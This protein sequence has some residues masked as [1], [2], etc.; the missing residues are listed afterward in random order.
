MGEISNHMNKRTLYII[1]TL[2][3]LLVYYCLLFYIA[4]TWYRS[5]PDDVVRVFE[6]PVWMGILYSGWVVVPAH[7]LAVF[8]L[9]FKRRINPGELIMLLAVP[10]ALAALF[11]PAKG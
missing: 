7:I 2:V 4:Q 1:V 10:I 11:F 5:I 6:S 8:F 3:L 9:S